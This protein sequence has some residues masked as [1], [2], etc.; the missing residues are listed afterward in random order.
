M[1]LAGAGQKAIRHLLPQSER[2]LVGG[3]LLQL[4]AL[5]PTD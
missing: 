5:L 4:P 2:V 1:L 3:G